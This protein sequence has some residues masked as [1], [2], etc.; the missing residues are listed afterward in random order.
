MSFARLS[1]SQFCM[2]LKIGFS[3]LKFCKVF[4]RGTLG[5]LLMYCAP[6]LTIFL[7]EKNTFARYASGII[8]SGPRPYSN[9][10]LF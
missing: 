4:A 1:Y 3:F 6:V 5:S 10:N 8:P 9:S 2:N 7:G